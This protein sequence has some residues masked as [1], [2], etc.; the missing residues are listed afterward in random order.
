MKTIMIRADSSSTIGTGHIMRD[1]VLASRDFDN[2]KVI[3]VTRDLPGN[4]NRKISEA[5]YENIILQ[6]GKIDELDDLVKRYSVDMI[7]ID[8]YGIG[9][10]EERAL[11]KNLS[12][13]IFVL[14][15]TYEKHDCDILL[16]HN[17]YADPKRYDNLVPENCELRCGKNFMLIRN[18]FVDALRKKD[19]GKIMSQDPQKKIHVFVAMG[20]ADTANLNIPI[21]DM[22]AAFPDL[23]THVVTTH[24]NQ[25][26]KALY[27]Y[28][29]K[30]QDVSLY[31]DSDSIATLM[32]RSDFAIVT[33]SVTLNEV[34]FMG[35]P[36][37]AIQ[38]ADNQLEMTTFLKQHGYPVLENFN[39]SICKRYVKGVI[40]RK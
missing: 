5:G 10:D 24:A 38:T 23:H 13:S 22:L 36:F 11:R 3:F 25:D 37:V 4:I 34:F 19:L 1:L 12:C 6:S 2:A 29:R 30:R 8:H 16:N 32:A 18:E 31:V 14:D 28:C 7:V 35:L 27:S 17:I 33:P 9:Y 20:G 40:G 21:L 39:I 15:D 26:L